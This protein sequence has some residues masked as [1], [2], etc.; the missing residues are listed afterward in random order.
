M[1]TDETYPCDDCIYK[2]RPERIFRD[3][4]DGCHPNG[5]PYHTKQEHTSTELKPCPYCGSEPI[6]RGEGVVMCN[7]TKDLCQNRASVFTIAAWNHRFVRLDK[8]GDSVFAG[9]KV[10]Y[11]P[12]GQLKR[13]IRSI[14]AVVAEQRPP[15]R[16][17]GLVGDNDW[18]CDTFYSHEIELIKEK[19]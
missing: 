10:K 12:P 2:D 15:W 1:S 13:H 7:N 6:Q 18:Y 4:C 17:Y 9:D 5:Y 11:T 8:N 14:N 16:G 19:L 3:A